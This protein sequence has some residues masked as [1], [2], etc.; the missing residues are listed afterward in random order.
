MGIS[1]F[2]ERRD[3]VLAQKKCRMKIEIDKVREGSGNSEKNQARNILDA[4]TLGIIEDPF[5][6]PMSRGSV[7]LQFKL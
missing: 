7:K 5:M 6:P 4:T 2:S 1:Y 3:S